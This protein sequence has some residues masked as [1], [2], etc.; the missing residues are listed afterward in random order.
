M[1]DP[2]SI[3]ENA[4]PG[5]SPASCRDAATRLL[6]AGS[7][8]AAYDLLAT[9]LARH[10][11]DLRLR[12]LLALSLV[13]TGAA[14][15]ALDT[16]SALRRAGHE[17]EETLG[18]LARAHKSLWMEDEPGAHRHLR[19]AHH[20]YHLAYQ[21]SGGYWSGINA[22]TTA[23]ALGQAETARALA[24][25]VR[26][27][28]RG[29]LAGRGRS[30]ADYWLLATTGE[31][32]LVLGDLAQAGEAYAAASTYAR[33]RPGDAAA[34]RRNARLVL[35]HL[36]LDGSALDAH[37]A[38]PRVVVFAGHLVDRPGR[39]PPR[40]PPDLEPAVAEAIRARLDAVRAGSGYASAACG[41]DLLF[42]EAL[43]DRGADTHIVLPYNR[44]EFL[45]DSVDIVP[46]SS[47]PARF[48]EALAAARDV[49]V[50][51]EH[52]MAGGQLSYEYA[53]RLLEGMAGLQAEEL[54]TELVP[55]ALWDG[56]PGDGRGGTAWTVERWRAAGLAVEVLDLAAMRH[57][58]PPVVVC[59]P[60]GR[61]EDAPPAPAPDSNRRGFMPQI[62]A[63]L[64]ADARGFSALEE[65]QI[66]I[67]V[68]A[69]LGGVARVL[70][71][72]GLRPVL[73]NTWGDGLYCVFEDV[74]RA[75]AAALALAG[76]VAASDWAAHGLP[77][78]LALRIA[79]HAGPAYACEDPVTGRPTFLGAHV[80]RAARI[81]PVTPPGQVYA[82]RAFA[83]LARAD[84]ATGFRCEYVGQMTL[85]KGAGTL[86]I[87]VV[88]R[89]RHRETARSDAVHPVRG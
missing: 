86:P 8:L 13:R 1:P 2:S 70:D 6:E 30:A 69:F 27:Q 78:D 43:R 64:F 65:H 83:A 74:A 12:Q 76:A 22:A 73:R 67:F 58:R 72:D 81:E 82:S 53:L 88:R 62:V 21:R 48:D 50:A 52:P 25:A 14:R 84:R 29:A 39:T 46:G 34:T 51:S 7:P 71:A 41:A 36:P 80:S 85:A 66:P 17:D 35:R 56:R 24:A 47:W 55:M 59:A 61:T 31:A 40:F 79:L 87:Y 28:C 10:P 60:A 38:V 23:L 45:A 15:S 75:G 77:A 4:G 19:L 9:A 54:D 89:R 57:A 26:D 42:L 68:E 32:C 63:M 11:A 33:S 5:P 49:V 20:Y 37:L 3:A 18:L 16:L 44:T